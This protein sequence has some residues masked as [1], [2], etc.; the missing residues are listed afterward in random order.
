[1]N[2]WWLSRAEGYGS[3]SVNIWQTT[4]TIKIIPEILEQV[5]NLKKTKNIR[6]NLLNGMI[7]KCWEI[8]F[9]I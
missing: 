6:E 1:M 3:F 2:F 9:Y 8:W 5:P 4:S 7:K